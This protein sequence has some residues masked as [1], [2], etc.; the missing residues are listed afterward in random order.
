MTKK[1][2]IIAIDIRSG[3]ELTGKKNVSEAKI[4]DKKK[5][6]VETTS[7]VLRGWLIVYVL[8][9]NVRTKNQTCNPLNWGYLNLDWKVDPDRSGSA[10]QT[11]KN[12]IDERVIPMDRERPIRQTKNLIDDEVSVGVDG[13]EPPTLCL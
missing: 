8:N 5:E 6:A 2:A 7:L 4:A 11:N 12:L 10:L 9:V 1:A 13:I 3:A